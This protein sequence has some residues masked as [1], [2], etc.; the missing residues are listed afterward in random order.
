MLTYRKVEKRT[1]SHTDGASYT[2]FALRASTDDVAFTNFRQTYY[3]RMYA[4]IENDGL[5]RWNSL[6]YADHVDRTLREVGRAD[7][8]D[9]ALPLIARLDSIGNGSTF[10]LAS[11]APYRVSGILMRYL[12]KVVD[13]ERLFG[14]GTE[15]P[16][17]DGMHLVIRL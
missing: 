11:G 14:S 10:K 1:G 13:L 6:E 7:L 12:G 2:D 17:F 8:I 3:H 15:N 16:T 4:G 5:M 9:R